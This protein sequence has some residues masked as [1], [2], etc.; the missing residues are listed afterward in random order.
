MADPNP[1]KRFLNQ[2]YAAYLR[3]PLPREDAELTHVE[4]GSPAGE[5]LRRYWQPVALS[6]EL[7]ELPIKVRIFGED[8]VLFRTTTGQVGLLELHCSHRGT[9][10][11]FGI[12]E[13]DGIR[14]CYH[15]WLYGV[16]GRVLQ[17]PGDPPGSTLRFTVCHGAYPAFEYKGLVFGYFGP[18]DKKPEFPVYDSYEFAGDRLVPYYITYPCNWLQVHE[19]VMDPAHAVF[20]H[21]RISYSHFADAWGELPAMEFPTTPAGMIYVTSRRWNDHVWVRSN[22]ILLPNLAQ[23]GHIWE[24]GSETKEFSRVAITRWTAPID[25]HTCRIIGW[26]HF[27]PDADP[28]GIADE[29]LCGPESVDFVGQSGARSYEERQRIPGDFD[30]QVSQRSIAVHKLE[31][32]TRCDKGVATLRQL[33]KR[34]I[35]ALEKGDDPGVS[36]LRID[37]R[38]PTY[39][40]DTVVEVPRAA[41][42]SE[43]EDRAHVARIGN[44]ITEIVVQGERHTARDRHEQ[45]RRL[46]REF[47]A[48]ERAT[49]A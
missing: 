7:G 4:A 28:R 3:G 6:S 45:V 27:H 10:L 25:N 5:L 39:C 11:E 29:K 17:T 21:T 30:A 1:G 34:Q 2:P 37:G 24:D 15:G 43:A 22:D 32:L 18:P 38:I 41:G 12:C 48:R 36:P 46:I 42:S 23:V 31:N 8:L 9:S 44:A 16:D 26:R 35:R 13:K 49:V 47:V 19:N 40:H 33:L 14:C 20:L